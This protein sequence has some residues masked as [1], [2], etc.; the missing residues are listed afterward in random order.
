MMAISP[1][2]V[3]I[4]GA[5]PAG[6]L[7]AHYLL[8]RHYRVAIY[9]NRPDP[10]QA[11]PDQRRSFPIS[12]QSRGQ[13]ALQGIPGL[14]A[15]IAQHSVFCRG[16]CVH[17]KGAFRSIP[18]KNP[19]LTIDRNCL[20]LVLL[21]QLSD[22]YRD[23][24]Q[25]RLTFDCTC[26]GLNRDEQTVSFQSNAGERIVVSYDRL[27]GADGARS[28]VRTA[29]EQSYG[30][31]CEQSYVPDTYKS[32]FLERTNATQG[33]KLAPDFIHTSN[34]NQNIRII[35]A[36]QPGDRLLHETGMV[37]RSKPKAPIHP[38]IA[39]AEQFWKEQP[40]DN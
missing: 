15:A 21:E 14:E 7:L 33:I 1:Q 23:P 4:V 27:I 16:T 13:K 32:I 17:R 18:R 26:E 28:R 19:V 6:L 20:V 37:L 2:N 39:F 30:L 3:V 35:L 40:T 36:P 5:G 12:L 24:E 9:D 11:D 25:L 31:Q 8:Q 29:L 38:A 22:R 34:L 10:R